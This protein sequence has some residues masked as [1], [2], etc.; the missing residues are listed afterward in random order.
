MSLT[1]KYI[2]LFFMAMLVFSIILVSFSAVLAAEY[3]PPTTPIINS[4]SSSA[5]DIVSGELITLSW[6][7]SGATAIEILG[8]EKT[9]ETEL[10]LVGQL[11]DVWVTA[12]TTYI[13]NA[14][15]ENGSMVSKSVD[16][17]VDVAGYVDILSFTASSEQ[18]Q[19][20]ETVMLNWQIQNAKSI[21]I[22][23][24]EKT[25]EKELPVV[26]GE[27][28]VLPLATTS[29]VLQAVGYHGE[30]KSA[31]VTVSVVD[32]PVSIDSLYINPDEI[33]L[34][35]IA[36]ITWDTTNATKVNISGID[37]DLPASGSIDV[38]P[39]TLGTVVYTITAT[40]ELG[41]T[42]T[43]TISIQVNAPSGPEIIDF[44]ASSYSV[45][46]GT[47]VKLSWD[48]EHTTGCMI[49]TS[50]G[51]TLLNRPVDGSI[52]LTPNIT[53]SYTLIAYDDDGNTVEK[54][55]EIVVN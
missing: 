13:L 15:G 40:G 27:L 46:R 11:E 32:T 39:E 35:D 25:P 18:I 16:V 26:E 34:G 44:S 7:V 38:I 41:D 24:L 5:T 37:E 20:G 47:L 10:P 31:I 52:S 23:G 1:K 19:L 21:E 54:T 9:P 3:E 4:F 12:S 17:N 43:D 2:K 28:E 45:S 50:D 29:Y 36:T 53:R 8:I 55:I 49:V 51:I 14:Y 42:Y 22:F 30:V 33:T 48:T 6:D